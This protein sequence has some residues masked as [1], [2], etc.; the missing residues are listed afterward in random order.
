M[1][2]R[3]PQE[4][5]PNFLGLVGG[6]VIQHQMDGKMGRNVAIDLI[7]EFAEL[8]GAMAW[9]ALADHRSRGDVLGCE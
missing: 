5:R 9:P 7:Q 4:P 8:H 3:T 1:V 2:P 6:I